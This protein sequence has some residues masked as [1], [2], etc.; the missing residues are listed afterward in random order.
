VSVAASS[1]P[2]CHTVLSADGSNVQER[3]ATRLEP[4]PAAGRRSGVGKQRTPT[5][6]ERLSATEGKSD[7]VSFRPRVRPPMAVVILFDDGKE[8]GEE[9]RVREG[10]VVIGRSE[11]DIVIP[12]D[13]SISTRH[14]EL[15]RMEDG[16]HHRWFLKD[17]GSTN[18]TFARVDEA[19]LRHHQELLLGMTRLRFEATQ[20]AATT[21]PT[22]AQ[23][24]S[25]SAWGV[26]TPNAREQHRPALVQL[27]PAGDGER[28]VLSSDDQVVGREEG[29]AQVVLVDDPYI[30]PRHARLHRDKRGRWLISKLDAENG[31]W[32][33]IQQLEV[34]SSGVFQIGEQRFSVRIP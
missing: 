27:T 6:K 11:G 24:A 3:T 22:A 19:I 16:G 21:S 4:A 2:Q 10:S 25:T 1:C 33:R 20:A 23:R 15:I 18:G 30:S 12:H 31:V 13:P 34:E 9:F 17:L 7:T 28:L 26:V 29:I 32:L 14:V 5:E 8:A